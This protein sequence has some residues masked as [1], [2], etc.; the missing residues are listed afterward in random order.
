ML[1][2]SAPSARA[3]RG[4]QSRVA[5]QSTASASR[6]RSGAGGGAMSALGELGAA[7]ECE[8]D[9]GAEDGKRW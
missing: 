5:A 7:Q 2:S 4:V 8:G 3:A 6:T 1:H 9:G